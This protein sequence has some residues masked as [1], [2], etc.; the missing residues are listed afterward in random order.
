MRDV[1]RIRT[2]DT[3]EKQAGLMKHSEVQSLIM[4]AK[5]HNRTPGAFDYSYPQTFYSTY[6]DIDQETYVTIGSD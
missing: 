4:I 2:E 1:P 3:K 6:P 5:E